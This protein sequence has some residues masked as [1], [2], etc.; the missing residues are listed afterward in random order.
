MHQPH[1]AKSSQIMDPDNSHQ[2]VIRCEMCET[3]VP[4]LYCEIC[5]ISLCKVCVGEHLLDESKFHIVVPFKHR[6]SIRKINYPE[7]QIHTTKLC[8]LHCEQCNIPVCVQCVSSKKHKIHDVTNI[9]KCMERKTKE[10]QADLEELG[11]LIYPCYQEIASSFSVQRANL[12]RNTEKLILAV[13]EQGEVWHREIDN[14]IRNLKYD[15][16]K[17]ELEHLVFLQKQEVEIKHSNSDIRQTIDELK[18]IM[19]INDVSLLCKYKSRNEEFRIL[20]PKFVVTL[21][22]FSSPKIDTEQLTQH[23]GSLS[24]L[25]R[26]EERLYTKSLET[27]E[28]KLH[29]I[30]V[31]IVGLKKRLEVLEKD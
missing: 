8:E 11:K 25:C 12:K 4:P 14:I 29:S 20:P 23:F 2:D 27:K 31:A 15:I 26:T 30:P 10:L 17:T 13:N 19:D 7:C 5:H 24:A 6:Q 16:E 3:P 9:S 21:P 28:V 22:S 18:K 1:L